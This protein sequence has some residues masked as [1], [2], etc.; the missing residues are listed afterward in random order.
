MGSHRT[1]EQILGERWEEYAQE[2]LA[3]AGQDYP[4]RAMV[5]EAFGEPEPFEE[6][7]AP[8]GPRWPGSAA[9][10]AGPRTDPDELA[11]YVLATLADDEEVSE[12]DA[13]GVVQRVSRSTDVPS[14]ADERGLPDLWSSDVEEMCTV[15]RSWEDRFGIRLLALNRERLVV[16][17]AAPPTTMAEALAVARSTSP[18]RRTPSPRRVITTPCVPSR[19]TSSWASRC[20]AS[21][22][23]DRASP[24]LSR[25][26]ALPGCRA[27]GHATLRAGQLASV[28][29]HVRGIGREEWGCAGCRGWK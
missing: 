11:A 13:W 17:V 9:P 21:G 10:P 15:L 7:I 3:E 23:T 18:S 25:P 5:V 12:G 14:L 8:F 6:L 29:G 19:P 16:S 22:G 27:G 24:A 26:R 4:G 2:A 20:G 1:V 28:C